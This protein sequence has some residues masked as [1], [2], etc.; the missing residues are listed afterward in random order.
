MSAVREPVTRVIDVRTALVAAL[1]G[2]GALAAL[3]L[4]VWLLPLLPEPFWP[5]PLVIAALPLAWH[6]VEW[7]LVKRRALLAG[8]MRDDGQVR[9]WLW[10]G[11]LLQIGALLAAVAMMT[12]LYLAASLLDWQH[13]TALAAYVLL[14][15]LAFGPA[16]AALR[17]EVEGQHLGMAVRHGPLHWLGVLLLAAAFLGLGF[18]LDQP[19]LR[20]EPFAAVL[21]AAYKEGAAPAEAASLQL[22]LGAANAVRTGVWYWAQIVGSELDRPAA[23]LFWL[24]FLLGVGGI[25]S[26]MSA[27][28]LAGIGLVERA[29]RA[30]LL[31]ARPFRLG[32]VATL[33][34]IA[35]LYAWASTTMPRL[36]LAPAGLPDRMVAYLDP[37]S[38][39]RAA[40]VEAVATA[41]DALSAAAG[42]EALRTQEEI[43]LAVNGAFVAVEPAVDLYLD[44]YFSL[45][46]EYARIWESLFGDSAAYLAG[47]FEEMV[48]AEQRPR[49]ADALGEIE[50]RSADR[51]QAL[52]TRH[53]AA[54]RAA[55]QGS[56]C[57]AAA[58]P[59]IRP[60]AVGAGPRHVYGATA[61]SAA[62]LAAGLAVGARPLAGRLFGRT[63]LKRGFSA[64]G[65]AAAG[66]ALCGASGPGAVLCGVVAGVG[67]WI[68][69]DVL[70]LWGDEYLSRDGMRA[71]L[72]AALDEARRELTE[73]LAAANVARIAAAIDQVRASEAQL[74]APVHEGVGRPRRTVGSE[75]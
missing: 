64:T 40:A 65:G 2:W 51:V 45:T 50:S 3:A 21:E 18:V 71:E 33:A 28:V 8:L 59:E 4:L 27:W 24:A 19:D 48:L 52:A 15:A 54:L 67:T 61:G 25:A 47:K 13:W 36:P 74:F 31:R 14:L 66:A 58:Q 34:V 70:V 1:A 20:G 9:A 46:G 42:R 49:L 17:S 6:L 72:M 41:G 5:I 11:W 39:S 35:A 37:C 32:F 10:R 60:S 26:L 68:A 69:V 29:G 53:S 62:G 43:E 73:A 56:R 22:L 44:W 7:R 30:S 12:A 57:L 55:F 23:W 38:T 63:A 75:S 16:R